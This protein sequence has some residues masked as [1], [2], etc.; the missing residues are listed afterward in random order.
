M[1]NNTIAL[2]LAKHLKRPIT[3]TSANLSGQPDVYSAA[4]IEKQF[5]KKKFQPDIIINAG[6]LPKRKP[7]TVVKVDDGKITVLRQGPIKI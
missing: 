2:D 3:A 6:R 4:S 1:P 7:S 5:E